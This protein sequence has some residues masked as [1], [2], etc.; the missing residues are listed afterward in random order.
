MNKNIEVIK[1]TNKEEDFIHIL[2][3]TYMAYPTDNKHVNRFLSNGGTIEPFMTEEM[4]VEVSIGALKSSIQKYI[5]STAKRLGYDEINSIAKYMGYDNPY[6]AEAE[7]LGLWTSN[8][9]A[10]IEAELAKV[11]SGGRSMP[12]TDEALA[13]LTP[14]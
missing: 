14:Y 9:W 8:T 5:D 7:A 1:F 4:V 2:P 3:S 6:R 11:M 10:Y 12:S 13:E